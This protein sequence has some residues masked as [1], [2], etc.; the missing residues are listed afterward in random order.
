MVKYSKKKTCRNDLQNALEPRQNTTKHKMQWLD[1]NMRKYLFILQ[2][3]IYSVSILNVED[4]IVNGIGKNVS[5]FWELM[6]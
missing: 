3:F 5:D 1:M 2:I 4:T 6:F